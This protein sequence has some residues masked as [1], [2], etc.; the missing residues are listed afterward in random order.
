MPTALSTYTHTNMDPPHPYRSTVKIG[1][2]RHMLTLPPF[3]T[4][5][6]V[7][8]SGMACGVLLRGCCTAP[9]RTEAPSSLT[10]SSIFPPYAHL[11]S[12]YAS[13]LPTIFFKSAN[14][15]HSLC[16]SPLSE[17]FLH[18]GDRKS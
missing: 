5:C 8:R 2:S 15:T 18:P 13:F 7:L 16:T 10:S 17:L 12:L 3:I 6:I 14:A 9:L 4:L 11:S 1:D